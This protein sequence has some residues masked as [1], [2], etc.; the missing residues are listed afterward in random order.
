MILFLNL[1]IDLYK[2]KN[3]KNVSWEES[4][5]Y[6]LL[7]NYT[8]FIVKDIQKLGVIGFLFF[9]IL[10]KILKIVLFVQLI[11]FIFFIFKLNIGFKI[12]IHKRN[13][14]YDIFINN[15]Q[16]L[17]YI[18]YNYIKKIKFTKNFFIIFLLNLNHILL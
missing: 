11:S 1:I 9:I 17:A 10:I 7:Y 4:Y 15:P 5:K 8:D 6:N 14:F 2:L 3:K 13:F 12:L 16:V 18:T